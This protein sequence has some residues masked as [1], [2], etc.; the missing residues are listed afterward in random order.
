V[1][2]TPHKW[3][4]REW[5]VVGGRT[6]R[7]R[8]LLKEHSKLA[9]SPRT[10]RKRKKEKKRKKKEKAEKKKEIEAESSS[11]VEGTLFCSSFVVGG[12]HTG[13]RT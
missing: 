7:R 5:G 9:F 12:R 6:G 4:T 1:Q 3:A 2:D 8:G 11:S 10:E 13:E